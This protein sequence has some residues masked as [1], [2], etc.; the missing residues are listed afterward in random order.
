MM[1]PLPGLLITI[2]GLL[3]MTT[4]FDIP[5]GISL[6]PMRRRFALTSPAGGARNLTR[7]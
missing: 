4:F 3:F 1:N 2:A 6:F 5:T 7:G